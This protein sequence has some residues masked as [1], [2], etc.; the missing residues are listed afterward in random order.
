MWLLVVE[1][2]ESV[3]E[4]EIVVEGDKA[5]GV[6]SSVEKTNLVKESAIV[7]D[8]VGRFKPLLRDPKEEVVEIVPDGKKLACP[9]WVYLGF[10]LQ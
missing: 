5:D 7:A 10:D 4:K 8:A 2:H 9:L 6:A 1:G 3:I